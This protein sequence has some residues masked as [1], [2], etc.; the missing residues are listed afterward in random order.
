M[1]NKNK[2]LLFDFDGVIVDTF[3]LSYGSRKKLTPDLDME[4]YRG[5]FEGN[6]HEVGNDEEK[7]DKNE[8]EKPNEFDPFFIHYIPALMAKEPVPGMINI[9]RELSKNYRMVVISSTITS[10]IE[11]YLRTHGVFD[12]FDKVYGAD[13]H[14]SKVIKIQMVFQDFKVSI[15]DCIFITDTLGDMREAAKVGVKSLGVIWGFQRS[16]TLQKGNPIAIV[17]SPQELLSVIKYY[18]EGTIKKF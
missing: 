17:S 9:L 12:L 7:S 8:N 11:E 3:E 1:N 5:F 18:E 10:P 4:T 15:E 2:T 6:I 13:V 14:K 16:E